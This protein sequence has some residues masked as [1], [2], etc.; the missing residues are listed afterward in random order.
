MGADNYCSIWWTGLPCL[1]KS[2]RDTTLKASGL[3]TSSRCLRLL[4]VSRNCVG[5][6]CSLF[7]VLC[8]FVFLALCCLSRFKI[9]S[10]YKWPRFSCYIKRSSFK[11]HPF[12]QQNQ[13]SLH[14]F[15]SLPSNPSNMDPT[16]FIYDIN[17]KAEIQQ[18]AQGSDD[19][20]QEYIATLQLFAK[21]EHTVIMHSS[22]SPDSAHITIDSTPVKKDEPSSSS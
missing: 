7:F 6:L 2:S 21:D 8:G 20:L 12:H 17:R 10:A 11:L 5:I 3:E 16:L 18:S 19:L 14:F 9:V 15:P 13:F 4:S 1:S 22:Y